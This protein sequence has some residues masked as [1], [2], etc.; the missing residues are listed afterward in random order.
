MILVVGTGGC[1]LEGQAR[2]WEETLK[3]GGTTV[4]D[5]SIVVGG[6][7]VRWVQ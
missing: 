7:C 4:A 2:K 5:S 6:A 1:L 3:C